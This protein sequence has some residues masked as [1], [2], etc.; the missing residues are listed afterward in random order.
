MSVY[1]TLKIPVQ[2]L[3]RWREIYRLLLRRDRLAF[4]KWLPWGTEWEVERLNTACY[5]PS[6]S[7]ASDRLDALR[8][9][10]RNVSAVSK[11]DVASYKNN[12]IRY[13]RVSTVW[14]SCRIT[15]KTMGTESLCSRHWSWKCWKKLCVLHV[16]RRQVCVSV[17]YWIF[18]E[19]IYR[20]LLLLYFHIVHWIMNE[21]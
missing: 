20:D 11:G 5:H 10:D 19:I 13:A 7:G 21:K 15:I 6:M 3:T 8:L 12:R 1:S 9:Q 16:R 2:N 14:A 18:V 4:C 17:K